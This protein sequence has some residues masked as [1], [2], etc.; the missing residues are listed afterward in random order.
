MMTWST[1]DGAGSGAPGG[2][3]DPDAGRWMEECQVTEVLF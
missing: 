2:S 3:C 1:L